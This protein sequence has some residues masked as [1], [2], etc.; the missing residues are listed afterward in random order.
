MK[1]IIFE[2]LSYVLFFIPI[3]IGSYS[4]HDYIFPKENKT[5]NPLELSVAITC[6]IISFYDVIYVL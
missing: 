4:L 6:I 1:E 2:L 5:R 3:I